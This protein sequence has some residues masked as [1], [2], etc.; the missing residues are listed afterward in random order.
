MSVVQQVQ[1]L[2][3]SLSL[4]D[5]TG[6]KPRA[7]LTILLLPDGVPAAPLRVWSALLTNRPGVS[8]LPS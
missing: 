1:W 2:L 7:H 6:G 3:R 8:S 4:T 5:L